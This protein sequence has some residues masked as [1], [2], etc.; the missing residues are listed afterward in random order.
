MMKL[1]DRTL[2]IACVCVAA[3][4]LC[5]GC[6]DD[7]DYLDHVPPAGQGSLI[8]D[9]RTAIDFNLFVDGESAGEVKDGRERIIDLEPG[10]RRVV[11]DD[12]DDIYTSFRDDIDILEG[13]LTILKVYPVLSGSSPGYTVTVEFD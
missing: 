13:Q 4:L 7:D 1:R 9:N 11:L 3:V 5:Q 12:D 2:R 6:E 8:V 10:I